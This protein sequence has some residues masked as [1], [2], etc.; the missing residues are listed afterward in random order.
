MV[1]NS[2]K[3]FSFHWHYDALLVIILICVI[4][5]V[6]EPQLVDALGR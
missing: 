6:E 2:I 4:D 5:H 3:Y 1:L